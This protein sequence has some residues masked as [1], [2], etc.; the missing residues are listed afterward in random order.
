MAQA[1]I[2]ALRDGLWLARPDGTLER[3]VVEAPYDPAHHRFNDGRCDPQG[4][5]EGPRVEPLACGPGL[6]GLALPSITFVI[7]SMQG[8]TRSGRTCRS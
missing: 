3:M 6:G 5:R 7:Q 2:I 8:R 1:F 4:Q